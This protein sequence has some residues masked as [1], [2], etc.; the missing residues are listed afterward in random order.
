MDNLKKV[1]K[2]MEKADVTYEEAKAVLEECNWDLLDAII[3][4]EARGKLRKNASASSYSTAGSED[5]ETVKT[6]QEI[7]KSYEDHAKNK[8][9][10]EDSAFRSLWNALKM[11]LKKSCENNFVVKRN[12]SVIMEIPVLLMIVLMI[13]FFWILLILMA[14]SLFCGF[15]Y[16]FS[17]P[18]LGRD[19]VNSA[20][21]KVSEMAENIKSEMKE[22][23]RD[24]HD[25]KE[26]RRSEDA[27]KDTDNRG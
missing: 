23:K 16:S 19:D 4:L 27:G 18:D 6:P 17:G 26:E 22:E 25:D 11:L 8:A 12:D 24:M 7:A 15:R 13:C 5:G 3:E 10:K 14:I 2:L 20:M 9:G 1:E 21:G